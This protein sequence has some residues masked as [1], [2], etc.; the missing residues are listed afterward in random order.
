[1]NSPNPENNPAGGSRP[2]PAPLPIY[3]DLAALLKE[4]P[5]LCRVTGIFRADIAYLHLVLFTRAAFDFGTFGITS[6][7]HCVNAVDYS[8]RPPNPA[9][10]MGGPLIEFHEQHPLLAEVSQTVPNS[11]GM[12]TYDPP[13]KFGVLVMDQSYFI[14]GQFAL[15]LE[16]GNMFKHVTGWKEEERQRR[17][18]DL[19]RGLEWMEPFRLTGLKQ[20]T[21]RSL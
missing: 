9:T 18:A 16:H 12:E 17:V 1:M 10:L 3:Y 4:N 15:R 13:V 2:Q 19:Q 20:F 5:N 7:I 8:I 21:T 6:F 11:D 14:A